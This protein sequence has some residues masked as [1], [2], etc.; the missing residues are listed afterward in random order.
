LDFDFGIHCYRLMLVGSG[1]CWYCYEVNRTAPMRFSDLS[2]ALRFLDA[3]GIESRS[4][5]T[6]FGTEVCVHLY[7]NNA[8]AAI[9]PSVDSFL[10][11]INAVDLK[12]LQ[13]DDTS[14]EY[15]LEF[16]AD[17]LAH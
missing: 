16:W 8:P 9:Y 11:W 12:S 5:D 13:D 4:Q 17:Y 7:G 14:S 10:R 1:C 6:Y 2:T 3:A 15:D